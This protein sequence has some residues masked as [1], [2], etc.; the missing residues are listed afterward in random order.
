MKALKKA[1]FLTLVALTLGLSS[2]S[3]SD[4]TPVVPTPADNFIKFKYNG[5][6]YNYTPETLNSLKKNVMGTKG[7][8]GT[9]EMLNLWL[10]LNV[11]VGSHNITNEP[12][13]EAAY[14]SVLTITPAGITSMSAT[15]GSYTITLVDADYVEGTFQFSGSSNGIAVQVTEGSFRADK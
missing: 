10:P 12:S 13:N 7:I 11:V 5:T 2:C 1:I 8:N 3:K 9:L 14:C 15:T 4:N 6:V